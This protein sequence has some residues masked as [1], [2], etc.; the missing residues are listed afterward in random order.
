M[1][2]RKQ[3]KVAKVINQFMVV[4]NAGL[5]DGVSVGDDYILYRIGEQITDPD[6]GE[7]LGEYEQ[8]IGRGTI[9]HVQ[10]R[11]S[12]LESSEIKSSGR[13]VI[14]KYRQTPSVWA[15]LALAQGNPSEE[16]IEEP[17]KIAQPFSHAEVGDY[18]RKTR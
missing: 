4:I 6:T 11:I 1:T 14:K 3:V 12:T 2:N 9:T 15:S 10:D 13:K 17:E 7:A 8:I 5:V 16:V 18:A